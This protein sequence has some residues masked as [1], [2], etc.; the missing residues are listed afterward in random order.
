MVD[1]DH[2][3]FVQLGWRRVVRL[4]LLLSELVVALPVTASG[5]QVA[6]ASFHPPTGFGG[7][8]WFGTVRQISASW[9]VPTIEPTSAD[10]H[11]ST[12]IGAQNDDAQPPF[13]QLGTTEDKF[14]SSLTTYNAFWSDP[15][16]GFHPQLIERVRADDLVSAAMVRQSSGW[17]LTFDD[18]STRKDKRLT[19]HY[20]VGASF[21][22]AEWLQEDPT[23]DTDTAAVD[24]PYPTM[25]SVEFEDL[26]VDTQAPSLYLSNGATLL[27]NGGAFLVP[28]AVRHDAFSLR[29]PSGAAESYLV[30]ASRLDAAVSAFQVDTLHWAG[31][32][33]SKRFTIAFTLF[34]AYGTNAFDLA[35]HHW[36]TKAHKAVIALFHQDQRIQRDVKAWAHSGLSITSNSFTA[37]SIDQGDGP[38][39]DQVRAELGLPPAQ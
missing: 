25:S 37:M 8:N 23:A 16:K 7:Y 21:D 13:I 9:R 26:R 38:L 33:K 6:T 3:V 35:F 18:V 34:A 19:I 36:P 39:A 32:S 17:V 1:V 14:S 29:P 31:L 28:S 5:A 30:A 12:W 22:Q 10:G 4:L 11:A 24:L 2:N 27:A 20:G 15:R